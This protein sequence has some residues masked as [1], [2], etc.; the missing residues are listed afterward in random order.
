[1]YFS[2]AAKLGLSS[3]PAGEGRRAAAAPALTAPSLLSQAGL[4]ERKMAVTSRNSRSD[5]TGN[6]TGNRSRNN[7]NN[8]DR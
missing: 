5:I 1:M 3:C 6:V 4:R 2:K 7:N 8:T